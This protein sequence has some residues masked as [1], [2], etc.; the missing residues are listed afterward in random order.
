MDY[1]RHHLVLKVQTKHGRKK[2]FFF[3]IHNSLNTE[4]RKRKEHKDENTSKRKL[5]TY[6]LKIQDERKK[7]NDKNYLCKIKMKI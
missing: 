6:D 3:R 5:E 7:A 4:P 1:M 2:F